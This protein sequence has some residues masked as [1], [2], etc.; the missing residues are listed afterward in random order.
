MRMRIRNQLP[1]PVC[2]SSIFS[3]LMLGMLVPRPVE[4]GV[5]VATGSLREALSANSSSRIQTPR[6]SLIDFTASALRD[7]LPARN[8]APSHSPCL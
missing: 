2:I 3:L 4:R 6:N 5:F 8:L 1:L 7:S